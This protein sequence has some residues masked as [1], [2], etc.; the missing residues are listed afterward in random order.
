VC[1]L[2]PERRETLSRGV[3]FYLNCSSAERLS[4]CPS[5][6]RG[7]QIRLPFHSV[8]TTG[9]PPPRCRVPSGVLGYRS[10]NSGRSTTLRVGTRLPPVRLQ[11]PQFFAAAPVVLEDVSLAVL[12]LDA[13]V[14]GGGAMP[15]VTYFSNLET[16][17]SQ[18]KPQWSLVALVSR[19]ALDS[20]SHDTRCQK[21][22]Q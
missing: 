20:Y 8:K 15:L 5:R 21:S 19:I 4:R 1:P 10:S 9:N 7:F 14:I 13:K 18:V 17:I 2:R 12:G 11:G 3:P 16:M 6:D 22:P